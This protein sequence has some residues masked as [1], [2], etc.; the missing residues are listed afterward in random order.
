M[1]PDAWH[2][3][4]LSSVAPHQFN[5]FGWDNPMGLMGGTVT[6]AADYGAFR[7]Q[8]FPGNGQTGLLMSS[9]MGINPYSL[10][11]HHLGWQQIPP[12]QKPPRPPHNFPVQLQN[13][14]GQQSLGPGAL[15]APSAVQSNPMQPVPGQQQLPSNVTPQFLQQPI[16]Q[17]PSQ[18]PQLLLQQQ[19]AL[20]S[21]Y[22]SSQNPIFQLQ[23]KLGVQEGKLD[24]R[25]EQL[26]EQEGKLYMRAKQLGE[27]E[28]KLDARAKQLGEQ[29]GKL[30]ARE[31]QLAEQECELDTRAKQLAEQ[32]CKLDVRP[33][34]LGEEEGDMQAMESLMKA[35]VTKERESNDELQSTRKMLIQALQ[36]LTNGR[37]HIGVK[38]MGELDPKTF[39]NACRSDVP[40]EDA[41]FNSAV[42]CSKW[43]AE[44]ANSEWH[45]FRIVTVDGK[46]MEILLEDD[47]KL[48]E[49]KEEQGEEIYGLVTKAL[50]EINEYNPSGRY[51]ETVLWNYKEDRKA[52]LQE[53]VQFV[54]KQW[55]SHKRKR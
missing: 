24:T 11:G 14:Q 44:I 23:H 46:L 5:N 47:K 21:N 39:A 41:Q 10:Q 27:Q 12:L 15:L 55:Q 19:P 30:D 9:H 51:I 13:Q 16:Q 17:M 53:A 18:A 45:P 3:S 25:A 6:P 34:Q 2:P 42:L 54:L 29:E 32:K 49:L 52:T 4:S 7:P 35:L 38:R 20:Q 8:M 43:Q 33:K 40:H 50:R 48:R 31:K 37:S 36:K 28:C 26:G 1:P 22:Q